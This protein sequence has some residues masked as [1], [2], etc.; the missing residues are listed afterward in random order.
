[1]LLSVLRHNEHINRTPHTIFEIILALLLTSMLNFWMKW[2]SYKLFRSIKVTS[3]QKS[4]LWEIAWNIKS[5]W[6][7]LAMEAKWRIYPTWTFGPGELKWFQILYYVF[8]LVEISKFFS[9][10]MFDEIVTIKNLKWLPLQ[11]KKF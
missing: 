7:Q 5:S 1:L 8:W 9:E 3:Y 10:Y 4:S 6:M 11:N 2:E